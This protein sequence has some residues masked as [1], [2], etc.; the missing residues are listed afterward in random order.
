MR[1][2]TFSEQIRYNILFQQVI[3]KAEESAVNYIK[4]FQN[5]QALVISVGN[6]YSEDQFIHN[7]LDTFHQCRKCYAQ[8]AIYVAELRMEGN[9]VDQNY[10]IYLT[11]KLII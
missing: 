3:H 1:K 2:M 8:I 9:F 7:C 10:Y 4:I 5:A 11:C 6:S